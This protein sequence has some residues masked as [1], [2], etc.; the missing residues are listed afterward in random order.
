MS[1][2]DAKYNAI[3]KA[4]KN[5]GSVRILGLNLLS[6]NLGLVDAFRV[7][8]RDSLV[9]KYLSIRDLTI[10]LTN[11]VLTLPKLILNIGQPLANCKTIAMM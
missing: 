10:G 7:L 4:F 9:G 3:V 11:A 2:N 1:P 8:F 5:I 6:M